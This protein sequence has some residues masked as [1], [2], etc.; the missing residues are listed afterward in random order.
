M[1]GSVDGLGVEFSATVASLATIFGGLGFLGFLAA[2]FSAGEPPVRAAGTTTSG[3][4]MS[5]VTGCGVEL[6]GRSGEPGL[7]VDIQSW[8]TSAI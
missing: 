3:G 7:S 5:N 2:T 8:I 4:V 6:W 1:E